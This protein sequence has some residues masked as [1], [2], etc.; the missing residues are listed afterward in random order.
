MKE[1]Q[2]LKDLPAWLLITFYRQLFLQAQRDE[3][4]GHQ[5]M[6]HNKDGWTPDR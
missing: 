5:F 4:K 2:N 1:K 3:I 6:I